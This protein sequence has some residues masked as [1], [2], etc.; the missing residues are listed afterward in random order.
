[1]KPT[2]GVRPAVRAVAPLSLTLRL[3]KALSLEDVAEAGGGVLLHLEIRNQNDVAWDAWIPN[4][5]LLEISVSDLDGAEKI[6]QTR[7]LQMLSPPTRLDPGRGFL[8]PLRI[9]LPEP[10]SKGETLVLRF[11]FAPGTEETESLLRLEPR[12]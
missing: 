4:G 11:R 6:R 8:L 10:P 5:P 7:Q 12:A 2:S 9:A 3:P 1:M